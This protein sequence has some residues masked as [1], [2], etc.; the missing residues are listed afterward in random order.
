MGRRSLLTPKQ[1]EEVERRVLLGAEP[2][3][4]LAREYGVD[5]AAIRHRIKNHK[6]ACGKSESPLKELAAQKVA[7]E[8]NMK[9]IS[10]VISALPIARQNIVNELAARMQSVSMHLAS[11]AEYGASISHRL[12]GIASVQALA[13]DDADPLGNVASLN[14]LKG[15]STLT[16]VATESGEIGLNLLRANKGIADNKPDAAAEDN[17]ARYIVAPDVAESAEEWAA[18]ASGKA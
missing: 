11:A 5:E 18:I 10:A 16:K 6:S 14:A 1:W 13:V 3:R 8:K 15:I 17:G 2:V 7:A 4:T 12:M 9:N